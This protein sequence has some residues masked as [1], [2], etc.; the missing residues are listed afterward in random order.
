MLVGHYAAGFIGKRIDSSVPLVTLM[1]AAM[2]PDLL[3]FLLQLV[4]VEH[5]G[6]TP[7][8][9]RYFGLN[10]YDAAIS[11]SLAMDAMWA[12]LFAIAYRAGRS[13]AR[14]AVVVAAV[15]LSHWLLDF[16][17][18]RPDMPLAP[19]ITR[20]VGLTLWDSI[21]GTL[22]V[23]GGIW[24]L[25]VLAYV[26]ATKPTANAGTYG[27]WL[28]TVPLT[29]WFVVT[30]FSPQPAGDFSRTGVTTFLTVHVVFIALAYVIERHRVVRASFS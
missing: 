5:A 4:G 21:L 22:V 2:L 20:K 15:V 27:L 7:G 10:A 29:L 13:D 14:G 19:G 18:H 23:E 8:F 16:I 24:L 9:P 12:A 6:L 26:R 11:H 28:M 17:T 1:A 25:A 30:P 3:T